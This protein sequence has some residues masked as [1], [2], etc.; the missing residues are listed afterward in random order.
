MK[1]NVKQGDH[2]AMAPAHN[3]HTGRVQKRVTLNHPVPRPQHI[4]VLFP[5]IVD[6]F[7]VSRTVTRAA[8]IVGRHHHIALLNKLSDN[9][10]LCWPAHRSYGCCAPLRAL[11]RSKGASQPATGPA[12]SECSCIRKG[13]LD[14]RS[15]RSGANPCNGKSALR[16]LRQVPAAT[17][18]TACP[19]SSSDPSPESPPGPCC[20]NNA[21]ESN[22]TKKWQSRIWKFTMSPENER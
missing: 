7:L 19:K 3:A 4:I 14:W 5:A 22:R 20:P 18:L 13:S 2:P 15:S 17:N 6:H 1:E 21:T 10:W 8:P 11:E 9:A 16:R 12:S